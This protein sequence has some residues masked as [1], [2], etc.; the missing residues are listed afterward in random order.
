M[1]LSVCPSVVNSEN[2]S[3]VN[4]KSVPCS[5]LVASVHGLAGAS[6]SFKC[7]LGIYRF[8]A[9]MKDERPDLMANLNTFKFSS[10]SLSGQL[11]FLLTSANDL[12]I[13]LSDNNKLLL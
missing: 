10:P 4:K 12:H 6:A 3:N 1:I 11:A 5:K 8:S 9:L 2:Y 7:I 13:N